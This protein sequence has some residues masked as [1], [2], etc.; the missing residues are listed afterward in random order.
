MTNRVEKRV[1]EPRVASID[2][3]SN[4][5]GAA[6]LYERAMSAVEMCQR[7]AVAPLLATQLRLLARGF[8]GKQEVV[9]RVSDLLRALEMFFGDGEISKL[10]G[11]ISPL[12]W[13]SGVFADSVAAAWQIAR[14]AM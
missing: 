5:A 13:W 11:S 12:A 4:V 2:V 3:G 9:A 1:L 8:R 6:E 10:A 14:A 7:V